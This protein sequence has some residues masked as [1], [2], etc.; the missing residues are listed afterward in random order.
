MAWKDAVE[1]LKRNK[2]KIKHSRT[3]N[4]DLGNGNEKRK[5][6]AYKK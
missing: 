4:I 5:Y 1:F 2:D 3:P 6:R